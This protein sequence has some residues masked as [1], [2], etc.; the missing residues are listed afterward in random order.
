M[1]SSSKDRERDRSG[2]LGAP[3]TALETVSMTLADAIK[4]V[5]QVEVQNIVDF[6][7]HRN[8]WKPSN[9]GGPPAMITPAY[10]CVLPLWMGSPASTE[11]RIAKLVNERIF[12]KIQL[13]VHVDRMDD[14]VRGYALTVNASVLRD[15]GEDEDAV[16]IDED[17]EKQV[18]D[19]AGPVTTASGAV[20][21]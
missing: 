9:D 4:A 20:A 11:R 17:I 7:A 12:P 10:E 21:F 3:F 2:A 5:E 14:N 13:V 1:S 18:R 16:A 6:L 15:E 19:A 8:N